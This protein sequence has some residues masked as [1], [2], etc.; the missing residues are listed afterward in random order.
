MF[1]LPF[2]APDRTSGT[3]PDRPTRAATE[4]AGP[5]RAAS[6]ATNA[7]TVAGGCE[8]ADRKRTIP[9]DLCDLTK[10]ARGTFCV[11]DL[12]VVPERVVSSARRMP[13][14]T[15]APLEREHDWSGTSE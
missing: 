7:Q 15:C 4:Q 14:S 10:L 13:C 11:L 6:L 5:E 12:D 9:S 8:M 1:R 3:P 2:A